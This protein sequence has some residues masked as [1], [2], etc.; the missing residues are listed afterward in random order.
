MIKLVNSLSGLVVP[1]QKEAQLNT[2]TR[3]I[4]WSEEFVLSNKERE[5]VQRI[6]EKEWS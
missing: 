6:D 5:T 4:V 1:L 2:N 3:V